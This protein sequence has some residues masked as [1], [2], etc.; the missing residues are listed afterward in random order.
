MKSFNYI[1]LLMTISILIIGTAHA[2]LKSDSRKL[3]DTTNCYFISQGVIYKGKKPSPHNPDQRIHGTAIPRSPK[4]ISLI[5]YNGHLVA[6]ERDGNVWKSSTDNSNDSYWVQIAKNGKKLYADDKN[7]YLVT[8]DG[9]LLVH[10]NALN[11]SWN[12]FNFE[13]LISESDQNV[14]FDTGL[15]K[16]KRLAKKNGRI[17]VIHEDR[18]KTDIYG[19]EISANINTQVEG[20]TLAQSNDDRNNIKEVSPENSSV[21]ETKSFQ[22]MQI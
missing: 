10:D 14:F 12:K 3:C 6:L 17:I 21:L 18:L 9:K 16:V 19:F 20:L 7:L 8:K 1:K 15:V 22:V 13:G 5:L 2:Y 11:V 4:V